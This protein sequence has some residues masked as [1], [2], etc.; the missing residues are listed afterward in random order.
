MES[1]S[2]RKFL[3]LAGLAG[4]AG[5]LAACS[6][7]PPAQSPTSVPAAP[8]PTAAPASAQSTAAP[9]AA[10]AKGATRDLLTVATS[11]EPGNLDATTSVLTPSR[12]LFEQIYDPLVHRTPDR[13]LVGKL[14][15]SW[16]LVNDTTWRFR[17]RKGV[18]FTNGEDFNADSVKFSL[19]HLADPKSQASGTMGSF[20]EAKIVDPYTVDV[21][22]KAPDPLWIA[23]L[24]DEFFMVPPK[25]YQEKGAEY[26]A[27]HPVGTGPFVFKEWVK[28]DHITLTANKDYWGGAPKVNTVIWRTIPE[29]ATRIAALERGEVDIVTD[30]PPSLANDL[31]KGGKVNIGSSQDPNTAYVGFNEAHDAVKD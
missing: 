7:A 12:M 22:T 24:T 31:V 10:P 28:A 9:A 25:Y 5:L 20:K 15:E 18:K 29:D 13:K 4:G 27:T 17:L 11:G 14:A 1:I 6:S 2:R 23:T 26:V 30:I 16:E 8:Q 19:E 21:I 3:R